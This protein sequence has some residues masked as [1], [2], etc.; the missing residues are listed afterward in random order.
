M[1]PGGVEVE[2]WSKLGQNIRKSNFR[3][4]EAKELP[5]IRTCRIGLNFQYNHFIKKFSRNMSFDLC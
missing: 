5:L 1:F 3:K 4:K 2:R